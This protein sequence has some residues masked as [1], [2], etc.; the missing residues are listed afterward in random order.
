MSNSSFEEVGPNG[1][2]TSFTGLEGGGSSAANNWWV[3]NN[4]PGTTTTE[5]LPSTLP[6]GGDKMLHVTTQ[7]NSGI[8]QPFLPYNT[9]PNEVISSAWVYVISGNVG[10]GT[11]NGGNTGLNVISSTTNQWQLLQVRNF[12]SPANEFI[13]YSTSS[14]GAEFYVDMARVEPVEKKSVPEPC[15]VF[16][17]LAIGALGAKAII[18]NKLVSKNK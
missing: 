9:G 10:I 5:L 3:W 12:V 15:S 8:W 11:G 2:S 18:K 17:L 13:V 1:S 4:T 14:S 6:N 7:W 16:G